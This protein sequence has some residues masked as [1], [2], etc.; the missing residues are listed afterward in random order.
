MRE[1]TDLPVRR[2]GSRTSVGL[3]MTST[4]N[5]VGARPTEARN[6]MELK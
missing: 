6:L 1:K 5:V 3:D 4:H 2:A